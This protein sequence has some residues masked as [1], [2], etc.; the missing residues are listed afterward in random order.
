MD[1]VSDMKQEDIAYW[2]HYR[3]ALFDQI[4][5]VEQHRLG[6]K[7]TTADKLLWIRERGPGDATIMKQVAH[8]KEC[9]R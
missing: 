9:G 4:A 3:G 2:T 6:M 5:A 7:L 8:I 1:N